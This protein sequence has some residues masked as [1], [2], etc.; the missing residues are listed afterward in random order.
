MN[1]ILKRLNDNL[2]IPGNLEFVEYDNKGQAKILQDSIIVGSY[3]MVDWEDGEGIVWRTSKVVEKIS[4][5]EFK[6]EDSQYVIEDC[7]DD[8]LVKLI[9]DAKTSEPFKTIRHVFDIKYK[10]LIKEPRT[11]EQ[12][13]AGQLEG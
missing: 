10:P 11:H 8:L 1:K 3:A 13:K 2:I 7:D 5:K 9:S 6:T 12:T 4:E